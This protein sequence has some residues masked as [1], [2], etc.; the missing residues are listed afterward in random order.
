MF[1]YRNVAKRTSWRHTQGQPGG[2]LL[3]ISCWKGAV[4]WRRGDSG[5]AQEP[6]LE[7]LAIPDQE[8]KAE[9]LNS[10][11]FTAGQRRKQ[12]IMK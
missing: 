2:K 3:L 12:I 5:G 4:H 7:S 11:K 6:V 10:S 1:L 8:D 9:K